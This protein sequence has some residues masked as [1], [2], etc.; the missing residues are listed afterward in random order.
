V[1]WLFF[2]ADSWSVGVQYLSRL[3]AW[4]HDGTRMVSPY[5]L[6]ALAGMVLTHLII[7]KDSNWAREITQRSAPVRIV[8]YTALALLIACLGTT[9]ASPFIYFQF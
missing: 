7:Q 6:L 4:R 5:I 3:L 1:G 9:D 2:R 8:N